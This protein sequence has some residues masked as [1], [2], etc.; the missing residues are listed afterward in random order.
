M[1]PGGARGDKKRRE[2]SERLPIRALVGGG[3]VG[4]PLGV[5]G[6]ASPGG[7]APRASM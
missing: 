6:R 1:S 2:R 7:G 3:G 5:G 4:E